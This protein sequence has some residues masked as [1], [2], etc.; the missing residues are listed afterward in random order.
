M[1][2]NFKRI[3][4]FLNCILTIVLVFFIVKFNVIGIVVNKF[5]N[6]I[7]NEGQTFSILNDMYYNNKKDIFEALPNDNDEII[8]LGDSI[9][10]R[11]EFTEYFNNVNIKNR[12]ISGDTTE[13]V[14]NRIDEVVESKPK[15]IFLL[16]GINDIGNG[17]ESE[18][19]INNY[20]KIIKSIKDSSPDTKIYV[21]SILPC[22]SKLM[23][24]NERN[25][26]RTS[27]NILEINDDIL[28]LCQKNNVTYIDLTPSFSYKN[29]LKKEYT[30]DGVHLNGNGYLLWIKLI[31]E[32]IY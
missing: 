2:K 23:D 31:K 18:T 29:E 4:V 9:T 24:D 22:N 19:I 7:N 16:I 17:V 6:N 5:S 8:F 32:Y 26:R 3:S 1:K 21:Q 14:L 25:N 20:N 13:G 10:D 30:E 27:K 28:K 11:G 15:K 12:G